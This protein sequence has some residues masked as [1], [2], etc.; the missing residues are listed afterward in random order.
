MPDKAID[1]ID[2]AA[3]LLRTEKSKSSPEERSIMKDIK[4]MTVRMEDAVDEQDYEKA[5]MYK[6]KV[7]M[8]QEKLATHQRIRPQKNWL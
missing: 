5:A 4:L 2:E 6:Q 3:A 7:S 8:L 1:V